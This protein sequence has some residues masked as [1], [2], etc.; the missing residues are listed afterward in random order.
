VTTIAYRDGVLAADTL[1]TANGSRDD[2]APK[3]E[4]IGGLLVGTTG[5]FP[6]GLKFRAWVARGFEGDCPYSGGEP[7]G[8]GIIVW[9]HGV[10][11][12]CAAGPWPVM[13][14]FYALGS[15][16]EYAIGAME[17]GASAEQAVGVAM[18]HATETG[19]EITVLRRAA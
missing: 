6:L 11:G 4:R 12:W 5:S 1:M 19:G 9:A 7:D 14:P 15:G 10:V 2:F 3:I 16:C 13:R 17:M 8:N 18:K